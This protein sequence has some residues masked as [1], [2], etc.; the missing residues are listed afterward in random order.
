MT[1]E[2]MARHSRRPA[3]DPEKDCRVDVRRSEAARAASRRRV[4]ARKLLVDELLRTVKSSTPCADC[5][6]R[7]PLPAME[8]DHVRGEKL[9]SIANFKRH[10]TL[11]LDRLYEEM[12]KCDLVCAVCHRVR[13]WNRAHPEEPL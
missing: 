12:A 5:G 3:G 1:G 9:F 10:P 13:E 8:F 4:A 6:G 11:S 7:Y 2:G